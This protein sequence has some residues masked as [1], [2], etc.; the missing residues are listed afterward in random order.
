MGVLNCLYTTV[1]AQNSSYWT[2]IGDTLYTNH[3]VIINGT[4]TSTGINVLHKIEADTIKT[5]TRLNVNGNIVLGQDGN[6]NGI[7]TSIEDL[8]IN[9]KPGFNFNTILNA[10][11]NGNVGIGIINP[12]HKLEVFGNSKFWGL[13]NTDSIK[14]FSLK[15]QVLNITDSLK[16]GLNSIWIGGVDQL[17]G[18]NHIYSDNGSLFLQSQAI[19]TFNTIINNN[20][21]RVGIGTLNPA[22]KLHVRGVTCTDCGPPPPDNTTFII[23]EDQLQNIQG[24]TIANTRWNIAATANTDRFFINKTGQTNTGVF[25][26]NAN[27][28]VGIGT[29]TPGLNY[30]FGPLKLDVNG[31]ARF[32]RNNDP[33]NFLRVGYNSANAIIDNFGTGSLLLNYYSGK[34]VVVG[35]SSHTNGPSNLTVTGKL[36][37]GTCVPANYQMAVDG[38]IAAREVVVETANWCDYVFDGKYKLMSL[39]ELKDYINK[40]KHLPEFKAEKEYVTNG[41]PVSEVIKLQQKKIEELTLY[42]LEQEEKIKKLQEALEKLIDK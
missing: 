9:S 13:L 41:I 1:S 33:N 40:N 14:A 25:T 39:S 4:I 15:T 10:G 30:T 23:I 12:S 5:S 3:D 7:S 24:Q 42:L 17:T 38:T 22:A 34:D 32:F 28:Q 19:S 37:V 36:A 20:S 27:E 29:A 11:T 6:Y 8:R 21:G 26:I 2:E 16:V 18:N 31:D 35:N